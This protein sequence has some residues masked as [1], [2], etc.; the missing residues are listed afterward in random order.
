MPNKIFLG[1]QAIL[2]ID[3]DIEGYE[4]LFRDGKTNFAKV[5]N[6]KKAT[7]RVLANALNHFGIHSFVDK[8][9][10]FINTDETIIL[11]SFMESI[12]KESF[13]IEILETTEVTE[14]L[15]K[16]IASLQEQGYTFAL[17]DYTEK[18][19]EKFTPLMQYI[20]IVKLEIMDILPENIAKEVAKILKINPEIKV[21]A[22][23]VEDKEMFEICKK[24]GCRLFQGYFFSKPDIVEGKNLDPSSVAV[25]ELF[26]ILNDNVD[27]DKITEL[28]D[29][30]PTMMIG[31]FRYLNSR[32]RA[33]V[34]ITT[35]ETAILLLGRRA[36]SSWVA[37]LMFSGLNDEAF[38]EPIFDMAVNR[39]KLMKL[40]AATLWGKDNKELIDSAGLIGVL[41]LLDTMTSI[42]MEDILKEIH[43]ANELEVA[44]LKNEGKLGKLLYFTKFAEKED[45][46][47]LKKVS[48][49]LHIPI[50]TLLAIKTKAYLS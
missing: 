45:E 33:N 31:L 11:S 16:R 42:S 3:G 28:F 39:S 30:N 32:G 29:R 15:I 49:K 1:K 2:D 27:M 4:L 22:E 9:T 13:V 23:K 35:I 36:L 40:L 37:L 48:E 26:N 46:K 5:S 12:P 19:Q 50:N 7:A 10:S 34:D 41:S 18:Y 17:D 14:S 20:S 8:Y 6:N 38:V 25:T 24:A 43:I 47:T 21:L 44:L